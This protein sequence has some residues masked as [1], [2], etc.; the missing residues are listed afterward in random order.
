MLTSRA[1]IPAALLLSLIVAGCSSNSDAP[2]STPAPERSKAYGLSASTADSAA[3]LSWPSIPGTTA[4][5][6]YWS[7]GA[8]VSVAT[9][10]KV[11][12]VT[13]P[14]THTGL[15]NG[16][17]YRYLFTAVTAVG[18]STPSHAVKVTPKLPLQGAPAKVSALAGDGR[19]TLLWDSVPKAKTYNVYWNTTGDVSLRDT[20]VENLSYPA[21]HLGL[22]N[23]QQYYYIITADTSD[24]GEVA[25][26]EVSTAPHSAVPHPPLSVSAADRQAN[27]SWP[28]VSDATA[29]AL[30]WNSTG[31][32][33]L[34]DTRIEVRDPNYTHTGLNN[35]TRYFYRIA[36][37]NSQGLSLLSAEVSAKPHAP[38]PGA[39]GKVT[40]VAGNE[41]TTLTWDAVAGATHYNVYWDTGAV[42]TV[43][44]NVQSPL[45]HTARRGAGELR[46]DRFARGCGKRQLGA[47]FHHAVGAVAA[48]AACTRPADRQTTNHPELECLPGALGYLEWERLLAAPTIFPATLKA[49]LA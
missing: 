42:V 36:A 5:N 7:S 10:S 6:V 29:Y 26:T 34:A 15:N 2:P 35:G 27:L 37:L 32:V 30:Y 44:A 22:S 21:V 45:V 11:A 18:E 12:N 19:I 1:W 23:G 39:P 28:A 4:Y 25:S 41:Q 33:S 14:Y 43:I 40:A 47:D 46:G 17:A 38:A 13:S 31:Q 8:D 24:F 48:H 49:I 9:A 16:T 3:T 20:K